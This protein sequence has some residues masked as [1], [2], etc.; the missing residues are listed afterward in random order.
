MVIQSSLVARVLAVLMMAA[1]VAPSSTVAHSA[2]PPPLV[3]AASDLQFAL[4]EIAEAYSAETGGKVRIT[5]GSSGNFARQ[6]RSGAP[7]DLFL[8]ADERLVEGLANEG[9]TDGDGV[10]Y[11]LG[12]LALIVPLGSPLAADGSL[13]DLAAA[14]SDGRLRK[15]AIANPEH[16]PYGERAREV[17][18]AK[19]LWDAVQGRL[20][21]GENVAQAAQFA[22]SG[23][24]DGGL[25]AYSLAVSPRVA[26]LAT[27]ALVPAE[28]HR[29]LRQRMVLTRSA[30]PEARKFYDFLQGSAAR[31]VLERHGF[32]LP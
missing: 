27:A 5:Y 20:V 32:T 19:G 26:E 1:I 17:L 8:S 24:A 15:L 11:A 12:R 9:L 23:A 6:I 22:T 2:D 14:L 3:A 21:F 16:A 13:A 28:W 31:G 10:L 30:G 25:V 29:P 18:Q 7:I 4:A